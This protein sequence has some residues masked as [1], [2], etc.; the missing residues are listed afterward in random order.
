MALRF[1]EVKRSS[2]AEGGNGGMS[3]E[4]RALVTLNVCWRCCVS[5]RF[6]CGDF[7][8]VA[9]GSRVELAFLML[10]TYV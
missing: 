3:L 6:C 1:C 7:R 10:E 8:C 2:V 9:V 4:R 5:Q